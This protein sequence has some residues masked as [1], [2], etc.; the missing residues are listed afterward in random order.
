MVRT[1]PEPYGMK[2]GAIRIRFLPVDLAPVLDARAV[3]APVPAN[4][5]GA[6]LR[7]PAIGMVV[8]ALNFLGGRFAFSLLSNAPVAMAVWPSAGIALAAL[9]VWG[10]RLWPA[11]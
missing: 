7:L 6:S 11:V 10:Y 5:I 2:L 9:M 4:K 1:P 3:G 8:A